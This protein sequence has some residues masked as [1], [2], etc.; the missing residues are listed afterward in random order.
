MFAFFTKPKIWTLMWVDA[1][2]I[3]I[4]YF[5]FDRK[6]LQI[7][8]ITAS[9]LVLQRL[10]MSPAELKKIFLEMRDKIKSE[11]EENLLDKG[12]AC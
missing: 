1:G 3:H 10:H 5:N 8:D 2:H 12:S 4:G 9:K 6:L 11:D 7:Y